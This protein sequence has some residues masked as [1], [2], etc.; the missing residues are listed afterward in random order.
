[1]KFNQIRHND[2]TYY[3]KIQWKKL[4]VHAWKAVHPNCKLLAQAVQL[5]RRNPAD[6]HSPCRARDPGP[7]HR[8]AIFAFYTNSIKWERKTWENTQFQWCKAFYWLSF[9]ETFYWFSDHFGWQ[10][11]FGNFSYVL[12]I[13]CMLI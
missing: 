1:M 8:G 11:K 3:S 6:Q 5:N 4:Q 2:T 9:A 7:D 13:F 10:Q 12:V